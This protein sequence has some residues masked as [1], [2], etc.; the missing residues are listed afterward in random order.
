MFNGHLE[1][2]VTLINP[3]SFLRMRV[4]KSELFWAV[5]EVPVKDSSCAKRFWG[6]GGHQEAGSGRRKAGH[7][8]NKVDF[9]DEAPPRLGAS[10]VSWTTESHTFISA[11]EAIH[12]YLRGRGTV[13]NTVTVRR[14]ESDGDSSR[15]IRSEKLKYL[16]LLWLLQSHQANPPTQPMAPVYR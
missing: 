14:S 12:S 10:S 15:R 11:W 13:G 4:K 7:N 9:F 8:L 6:P 2:D 5:T 1:G 16:I 3:R